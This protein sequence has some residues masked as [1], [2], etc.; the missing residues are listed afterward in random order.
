MAVPLGTTLCLGMLTDLPVAMPLWVP[1]YWVL[2]TP[3]LYLCVFCLWH[4]RT[5]FKGKHPYAWA[6][7]FV[8]GPLAVPFLLHFYSVPCLLYFLVHVVRDIFGTG[9]YAPNG[10]SHAPPRFPAIDKRYS[11]VGTSCSIAGW[12]LV[13]FG[14]FSAVVQSGVTWV[15]FDVFEETAAAYDGRTL[16]T[17][18]TSALILMSRIAIMMVVTCTCSAASAALGGVLLYLGERFSK[19]LDGS[20]DTG[21]EGS[22]RRTAVAALVGAIGAL[23]VVGGVILALRAREAAEA[24]ANRVAS[25]TRVMVANR[26]LPTGTV[27]G[28][29]ELEVEEVAD[30]D[31]PSG[32]VRPWHGWILLGHKTVVPLT[33][34]QAVQWQ[35]TDAIVHDHPD[36]A[37]TLA[38]RREG[39]G[40]GE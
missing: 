36:V 19:R 33:E 9:S 10:D 23:L 20:E 2:A 18:E 6:P 31:L 37:R 16:T 34:G 1:I 13:G 14:L 5:R 22:R 15:I 25:G 27:L 24:E 21:K 7:L 28:V 8:V 29:P 12:A 38:R 3:V 4:W 26:D 39:E 32:Y 40:E 35:D 30:E 17:S 11:Y